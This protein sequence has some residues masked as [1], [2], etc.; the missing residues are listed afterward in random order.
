MQIK[1]AAQYLPILQAA[2]KGKTI[3]YRPTPNLPWGEGFSLDLSDPPE[4]YRIKPQP[5]LRPWTMEEVPVGALIRL[6]RTSGWTG[7]ITGKAT[8]E[9]QFSIVI[10]EYEHSTDGGKTWNPCGVVEET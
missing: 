1:Y 10:S 9:C 6:K 5:T 2:V 8:W 4:C 3:Q 7:T